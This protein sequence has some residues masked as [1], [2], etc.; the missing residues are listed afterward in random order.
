MLTRTLA[1]RIDGLCLLEFESVFSAHLAAQLRRSGWRTRSGSGAGDAS[2][3]G[4][5]WFLELG[6]EEVAHLECP[7]Q[8]DK[9]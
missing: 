7:P 8:Q 1:Q 5:C 2:G 3:L 6:T 4:G 9:S